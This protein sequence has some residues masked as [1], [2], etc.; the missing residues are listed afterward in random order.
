[1]SKEPPRFSLSRFINSMVTRGTATGAELDW[2]AQVERSLPKKLRER[3][4]GTFVPSSAFAPEGIITRDL[5]TTTGGA[6]LI[7]QRVRQAL[8]VVGWSAVIRSGAQLLGPLESD[9][10]SVFHDSNLPS[11]SWQP[12]MGLV[13]PAD[14]Q[15]AATVLTP[16]R[17]AAQ[18]IVSRQLVSQCGGSPSLD[19]FIASRLRIALASSL[20][21]SVLYG[22]GGNAPTGILTVAGAQSVTVSA[23]P[24][25][26]DL[27]KM[28]FQSTN[29]D[30]DRT[31]FGFIG[32]PNIRR[33]LEETSRFSGG[34]TTNWDGIGDVTEI[35]REVSDDRIFSGVWAY[36]AI[37]FWGP[38][39][40]DLTIDIV[41]DPY[42]KAE[43]GEIVLT[44]GFYCDVAV[45]FPQLFCFSQANAA[46]P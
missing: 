29:F 44:G 41:I 21:Q 20:D 8:G 37:A 10:L 7:G 45:R 9:K 46:G 28:C 1:M 42:S 3:Q 38:A 15:F 16:R 17:I 34:G 2:S 27:V 19:E 6:A 18:T 43:R 36:V 31:S 22:A 5:T 35:S 24:L 40:E 26:T 23:P 33:A 25:W 13:T 39:G 32:S 11:A 30:V 14:I 12:E 4:N